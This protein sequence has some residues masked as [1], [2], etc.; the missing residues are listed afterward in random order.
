MINEY[1][2]LVKREVDSSISKIPKSDGTISGFSKRLQGFE[3]LLKELDEKLK[4][5]GNDYLKKHDGN[6][7]DIEKMKNVNVEQI[8]RFIASMNK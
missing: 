4:K 8:K 1:T 2:Q 5:L 7:E 6:K 3:K